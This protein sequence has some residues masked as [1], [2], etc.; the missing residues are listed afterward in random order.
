M[1]TYIVQAGDT[2]YGISK[3]F[4]V[5]VESI[6]VENNLTSDFLDVGRS[7]LIPTGES[8]FLYVVKKGDT[9]Y[10]IAS[11][12]NVSV[13]EI[14][15]INN[16]NS[17]NLSIGQQLRIPINSSE[18]FN[19]LTYTVKAG[20][21]LYS[22]A[23][24]YDTTVD[25]IKKLNNLNSNLLNIG[26]VLKIAVAVNLPSSDYDTYIVK[27][28]DTLYSIAKKFGMTVAEIKKINNLV[29]DNLSIG[30]VLRVNF[31]VDLDV[32]E[33]ESCYGEGYKEPT[34]LTYTVKAGDSL[35]VIGRR[36]G[37]GVDELIKLNNLSS[38]NLSVGQVLKIK[39]V[40]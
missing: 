39:E 20:D 2:L 5:S 23:K 32:L 29:N 21:T 10:S 14:V 6:K 3:Q 28:G 30:Q 16:L 35:Y 11:K 1:Q 13:L 25:E 12:Y 7:L 34:Y 40:S 37:V 24:K 36:Y 19:Y 26:Q 8:S 15:N 27:S 22:V 17:N 31:N 38:N 9:L 4:G 18:G 33:G